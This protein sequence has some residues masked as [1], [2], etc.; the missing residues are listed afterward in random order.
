[1]QLH[2]ASQHQHRV[3]HL[4]SIM[5]IGLLQCGGVE[6]EDA[7]LNEPSRGELLYKNHCNSCHGTQIHWR[8]KKLATDMKS[9]HWQVDRWQGALSLGW[10]HQDVDEVA[11]YL[12]GLYYHYPTFQ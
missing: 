3:K 4:I 5:L 11:V 12:N 7:I 2:S 1:M 6:A 9:I 8:E 10:T